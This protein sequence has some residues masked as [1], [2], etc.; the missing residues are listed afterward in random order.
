M[1]LS[2]YQASVPVFVQ[3]LTSLRVVLASHR[4]QKGQLAQ[5]VPQFLCQISLQP[6][7]LMG[8]MLLIV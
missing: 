8:K 7:S 3:M 5:W 6:L 1:P 4:W 2:M